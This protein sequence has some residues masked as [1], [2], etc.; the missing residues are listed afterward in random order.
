[1]KRTG[2]LATGK[3]LS[4]NG[5]KLTIFQNIGIPVYVK[6]VL[7][8]INIAVKFGCC[9]KGLRKN[10]FHPMTGRKILELVEKGKKNLI[11]RTLRNNPYSDE[12]MEKTG[13]V[14]R[15]ELIQWT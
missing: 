7:G 5:D 15:A 9:R 6:L 14:R 1:M 3:I 10:M 4:H 12:L 2:N 8:S 13:N 11:N